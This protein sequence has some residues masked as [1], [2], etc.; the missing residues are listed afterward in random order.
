MTPQSLAASGAGAEA[1]LAG[2]RARGR[3]DLRLALRMAAWG[4]ALT[5]LRHVVPVGRIARWIDRPGGGTGRDAERERE[6]ARLSRRLFGPLA[7]RRSGCYPRSLLVF[8]F[9]AEAGARP[10]LRIGMRRRGDAIEGHAWVVVD[11]GPVDEPPDEVAA[12]QVIF[13]IVS[14]GA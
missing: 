8:R 9:L 1:G 2:P 4:V 5:L 3:R 10:V 7:A 12:Y 6:I 11:G 13:E 14:E